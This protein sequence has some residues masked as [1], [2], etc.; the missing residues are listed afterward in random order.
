MSSRLEN[1][2]V[3]VTGAS[4]GIGRA[5][6]ERMAAEGASVV[7]AARKAESLREVEAELHRRGQAAFAQPCHTGRP[8]EVEALFAAAVER[9]GRVDGLV[10]NAATNPYFGP[11]IDVEWPAWDKTF[12]VNVKGYFACARALA[13]HLESRGH[14]GSVVQVASI[15]GLSGA[16]LQGVYGMTK[17]AVISMT[18][19][20]AVEWAGL[21]IRVNAIAPGIIDT[22]FAGAL[23]QNETIASE[24]TRRTPVGRFGRPDE[25]A[26][27][28][29]HLVGDG[30]SYTTG[31]VFVV[32]GGLTLT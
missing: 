32:D 23:T 3:V 17:A 18:K 25:V 24:L 6:A 4:R 27:L 12:E 22:R 9:F 19:S 13:R 2:V 30:S 1:K 5:I 31:S 16:P 26:E 28:A 7:L 15:L 14:P 20:L 8:E 11:F 21:G 29:A 10:N